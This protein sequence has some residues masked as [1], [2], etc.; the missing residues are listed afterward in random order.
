[1]KGGSFYGPGGAIAPGAMQW[2][3]V[4]NNA[5]NP[6][7][8]AP[9]VDGSE[10]QQVK[11]AG[12]RRRKSRKASKKVSRRKGGRHRRG[13]R[14]T[15]KMRGGATYESVAGVGYGY[16]GGGEAGLANYGGYASKVGGAGDPHTQVAG[17][18]QV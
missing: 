3:A 10:L 9:I 7:T 14:H 5:A 15:R 8:G 2:D 6:V 1:M 11:L 4:E 17:V 13:R 16:A 12:G 18:M